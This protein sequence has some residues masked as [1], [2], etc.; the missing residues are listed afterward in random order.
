MWE[1]TSFILACSSP[2]LLQGSHPGRACLGAGFNA[3]LDELEKASSLFWSQKCTCLEKVGDDPLL[4]RPL[5]L[6]DLLL[7][8][9]NCLLV[10][11]YHSQEID[12][13][14]LLCFDL[15]PQVLQTAMKT[16]PFSLE[17]GKLVGRQVE[18]KE[19]WSCGS[20]RLTPPGKRG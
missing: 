2:A 18:L 7:L 12:E 11:R 20:L 14:D 10:G 4:E 6:L 8:L 19:E 15:L 1:S 17:S 16:V 13:L 5:L 3:V 9:F